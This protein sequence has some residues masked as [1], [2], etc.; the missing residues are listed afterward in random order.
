[1]SV[2]IRLQN[3]PWAANALDIRQYF[4]GLSIPEGGVHI[5]GGE[6]GDAFIA[7][8][9][10]EDARQA[11]MMDGGKIK[12]VCVRL[13]LS[14]RTEMQKVIEMARSQS[15]VLQ[16]MVPP[17]P[18]PPPI[19]PT[20][21][22][23][24]NNP[25]Q[26]SFPAMP[27][28][29]SMSMTATPGNLAIQPA[30]NAQ[31]TDPLLP[32]A[33]NRS[34]DRK[35]RDRD[36]DRK[37]RDRDKDRNRGDRDRRPRD[38]DRN[39]N[40]DRNRDKDRKSRSRSK[41]R[42]RR[43]R[44]QSRD[45]VRD[46]RDRDRD[47][48]RNR[49]RDR[50]AKGNSSRDTSQT[51]DRITTPRPDG[52]AVGGGLLPIP[53]IPKREIEP[54][55]R[56]ARRRRWDGDDALGQGNPEQQPMEDPGRP[57]SW[58]NGR[59]PQGMDADI[60]DYP[61][62][63]GG[64][65]GPRP[66][67]PVRQPLLQTPG[68]MDGQHP[69]LAME[70]MPAPNTC[71]EI[72]NCP[73]DLTHRDLREFFSGLRVADIKIINDNAGKR[74]GIAYV[75]FMKLEDKDMAEGKSGEILK[76]SRLEILHLPDDIFDRA[77]DMNSPKNDPYLQRSGGPMYDDLDTNVL[78]LIGVPVGCVEA[79]VFE[80]F[81][82][83]NV[84]DVIVDVDR[85]GQSTGLAFALF[86][87]PIEA[88]EAFRSLRREY[89]QERSIRL[90]FGSTSEMTRCRAR[91]GGDDIMPHDIIH[92]RGLPPKI[93]VRE[94]ARILGRLPMDLGRIFI[95]N[96]GNVS[97][98]IIDGVRPYD[99]PLFL[100]LNGVIIHEFPLRVNQIDPTTKDEILMQSRGG[101]R[102]DED[103]FM[104]RGSD[105]LPNPRPYGMGMMRPRFGGPMGMGAPRGSRPLLGMRHPRMFM[106]SRGGF[107]GPRGGPMNMHP[108]FS[109][110]PQG[111]GSTGG[112]PSDGNEEDGSMLS[113]FGNPG[114]VVGME[115]VPYR[116]GVEDILDF[117]KDYKVHKD[118][119]IRRYDEDGKPTAEAR[120]AFET[121]ADAQAAVEALN[122]QQ[123]QG[124]AIYL[125]II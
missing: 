86:R 59:V 61:P 73:L 90:D 35:D 113:S 75:R 109:G 123:M 110:T 11:M 27:T 80:F 2:I 96:L 21:P 36:R 51:R 97:E 121:P 60:D 40:R 124:R 69:R 54:W 78:K 32:N 93:S 107:M 94:V 72:R 101:N 64:G 65:R 111:P 15:M 49:D 18:A 42:R 125:A 26:M 44:S 70:E 9:T 28:Q 3:L 55:D 100:E 85:R 79:D 74:T 77:M 108:R 76:D 87:T 84:V 19:I 25:I 46:R 39:R 1:M 98:A 62:V 57:W 88:K 30:L 12:E 89:F 116:A 52:P 6:Q 82:D 81:R 92:I 50:D 48:D 45:R 83:F 29:M 99:V 14:S 43:T 24:P 58:N 68:V 4:R 16:G 67:N 63:R 23:Q 71:I 120:V 117:F 53:E 115:N 38:V 20:I 47:R 105:M 119:V 7:F 122:E 41:E 106:G 118:N 31:K 104:P 114:C 13:L 17:A 22:L 8:S 66:G 56:G 102:V 34:A 10:D 95:I 37:D 112:P 103:G 5:V 33:D 91:Q